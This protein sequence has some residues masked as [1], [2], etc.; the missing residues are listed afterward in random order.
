MREIRFARIMREI[1]DLLEIRNANP[2]RVRAYRSAARVVVA[3]DEVRE[4]NDRGWISNIRIL[5]MGR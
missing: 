2:F 1:A 3:R 4:K 5:E